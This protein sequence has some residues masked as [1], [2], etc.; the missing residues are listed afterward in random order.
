MALGLGFTQRPQSSSFG[1]SY[2]ESY[3]VTP[4][5]NYFGALGRLECL[6]CRGCGFSVSGSGFRFGD[7]A[8]DDED[9][10]D[11]GDDDDDDDAKEP[12]VAGYHRSKDDRTCCRCCN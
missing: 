8:D 11:D 7:E 12:G 3:K 10:D 9:H 5:R 1:G 4:K 6:G 2:I